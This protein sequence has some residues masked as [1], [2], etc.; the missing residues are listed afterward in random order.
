[1]NTNEESR[2]ENTEP[3]LRA[4]EAEGAPITSDSVMPPGVRKDHGFNDLM[5][6]LAQQTHPVL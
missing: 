3:T 4:A 6:Q 1:M 2:P 5:T